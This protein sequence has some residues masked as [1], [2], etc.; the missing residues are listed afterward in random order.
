MARKARVSREVCARVIVQDDHDPGRGWV[1]GVQL[2][3]EGDELATAVTVHD[4]GVNVAGAQV[5]ARHQGERPVT[6]VFVVAADSGVMSGLRRQVG[7]HGAD[8]L[9]A[10]L[11]VV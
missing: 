5:E 11:L 4:G 9:D 7:C 3:Q 10:R 2:L 6:P 8:R 1:G